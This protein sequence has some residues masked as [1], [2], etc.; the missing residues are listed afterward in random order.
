VPERSTQQLAGSTCSPGEEQHGE[1]REKKKRGAPV[2]E[3]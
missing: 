3:E 1:K 2:E